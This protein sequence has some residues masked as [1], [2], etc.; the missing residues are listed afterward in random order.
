[1][2]SLDEAG[3]KPQDGNLDSD[4]VSHKNNQYIGEHLILFLFQI[5]YPDPKQNQI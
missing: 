2:I 4:S 3:A 1:V 5:S